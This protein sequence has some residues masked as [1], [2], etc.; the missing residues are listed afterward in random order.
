MGTGG[1]C[2]GEVGGTHVSNTMHG[3][4][5]GGDGVGGGL[6]GGGRGGGDGGGLSPFGGAQA[7]VSHMQYLKWS[8][9]WP[10]APYVGPSR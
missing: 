10:G 5:G 9:Y 6:G 2:G 8:W 7:S 4:G 1:L 3:S